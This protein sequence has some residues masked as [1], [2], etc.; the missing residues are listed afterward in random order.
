[1]DS[2]D[3]AHQKFAPHLLHVDDQ[4]DSL[5][6]HEQLVVFHANALLLLF[7]MIAIDVQYY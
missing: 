7:L 5:R 3:D 6:H 4:Q 2:L 1:M